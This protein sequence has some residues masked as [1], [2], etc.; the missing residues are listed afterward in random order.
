MVGFIDGWCGQGEGEED[1]EEKKEVRVV[2]IKTRTHLWRVVGNM[3]NIF[4]IFK[5][6]HYLKL[7]H[8]YTRNPNLHLPTPQTVKE[9]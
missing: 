4:S 6:I 5:H 8:C 9:I 1:E 7:H 2:V 3:F